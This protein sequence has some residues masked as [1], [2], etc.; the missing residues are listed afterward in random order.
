VTAEIGSR[1]TALL[2]ARP[3]DVPSGGF[4]ATGR[5]PTGGRQSTTSTSITVNGDLAT[6][7]I[8]VDPAW[9]ARGAAQSQALVQQL[10]YTITE[11]PG[12][13]RAWLKDPGKQTFTI[14]QLVVEKPLTRE[15]VHGYV[16]QSLAE[17]IST[18]SN[19]IAT[20]AAVTHSVDSVA[21]G[22]ARVVIALT[23]VSGQFGPLGYSPRLSAEVRLNDE[24]ARPAHGKYSLVLQIDGVEGTA[25][26]TTVDRTP[27]RAIHFTPGTNAQRTATYELALDDL[28]PWRIALLRGPAPPRVVVDIGGHPGTTAM[29]T[30]VYSPQPGATAAR[31]FTV[32]G[33]AR[34]FEATVS[35]RLRD[36]T[37]REV[38]KGF[39]TASEGSSSVWGTFEFGVQV[40]PSVTGNVT[41][42][43]YQ[44]S[45]RDGS[46]T[47]KVSMPLQVR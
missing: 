24:A 31:D 2:G 38:A 32:S 36:S 9:A 45:P 23:P 37:G 8:G 33:L 16:A 39:T 46:D 5:A 19:S 3:E 28:R 1:L 18:V 43:V 6:V 7:E 17:R 27:L 21:P 44:A 10:I 14:D 20:Q 42:E 22:L 29:N 30:V 4:N 41:L 13:R 12:I 25:S 40:P 11:V 35:W 47:D 34:A 26:T 15:D